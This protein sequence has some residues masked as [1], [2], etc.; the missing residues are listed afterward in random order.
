MSKNNSGLAGKDDSDP[1][2]NS[3]LLVTNDVINAVCSGP[4]DTSLTDRNMDEFNSKNEV[5]EDIAYD[6]SLLGSP[7]RLLIFKE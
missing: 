1:G 4:L 7:P 5:G 3:V 2:I 6:G